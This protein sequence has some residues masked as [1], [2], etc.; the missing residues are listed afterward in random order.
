MTVLVAALLAVAGA[1]VARG[2]RSHGRPPS[3]SIAPSTVVIGSHPVPLP[4]YVGMAA[5][6]ALGAGAVALV[7]GAAPEVAGLCAVVALGVSAWP[8]AAGPR[9]RRRRVSAQVPALAEGLAASLAAGRSLAQAVTDAA[10]TTPEPLGR[11]IGDAA[12]AVALGER[13]E[14][15]LRDLG[16]RARDPALDVVIAAVAI[17][18]RS[19]G[20]LAH[21]LDA[22]AARL[23]ERQ[24]L[25]AEL[26]SATAQAR[27]TGVIVAV[28][29]VA[30]GLAFELARPGSVVD[31]A[32]GPG[33]PLL[34]GFLAAQCLALVLI[35]RVSRAAVA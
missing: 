23:N 28:L 20:D 16:E 2:I 33:K 24:R 12:R 34:G 22:L 21:A 15:A 1:A 14:V 18:R 4:V 17:Q 3:G 19:G 11:Q 7:A 5:T 29:P 13:V 27:M 10:G 25:D 31:L 32:L 6:L 8:A 26:R 9:A 35:R 30:A